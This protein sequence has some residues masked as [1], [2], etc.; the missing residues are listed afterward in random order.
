MVAR[1]WTCPRCK[2]RFKRK[3]GHVAKHC[4][5]GVCEFAP[6]CPGGAAAMLP[7]GRLACYRHFG[8]HVS[9][10]GHGHHQSA[11]ELAS[12]RERYRRQTARQPA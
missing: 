9:P 2:G 10:K 12:Q 7:D 11:A 4:R 1:L 8:G 5:A 6:G 3:C